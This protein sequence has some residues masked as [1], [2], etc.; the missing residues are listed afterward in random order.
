LQNYVLALW[1][2]FLS[3]RDDTA[4]QLPEVG[5]EMGPDMATPFDPRMIIGALPMPALL[6]GLDDTVV[7]ANHPGLAM[8]VRDGALVIGSNFKDVV[9][10]TWRSS[11]ARAL[12]EAKRTGRSERVSAGLD[13]SEPDARRGNVWVLPMLADDRRLAGMLVAALDTRE[14]DRLWADELQTLNEQLQLANETL[15]T[16][17][18][19]V[20]AARRADDERNQFLAML[21]HELRNPLAGI[22]SASY[23]LRQRLETGGDRT[24]EQALRVVDRQVKH[25]ARLLDDLL[26]VSRMVLG[27][28]ALR[29]ESVDLVVIVRQA[30][31]AASFGIHS[32]AQALRVELPD[33]PVVVTGDAIRL[34]QIVTNL[35]GN[36]VKYTPAAGRIDLRLSTADETAVLK[37]SDSGIGIEPE[38][39]DKIFELFTQGDVT[40]A[41]AAGGLGI[42]LTIARALVELH[43]GTITARSAGRDRGATFEVRL[44]R[45]QAPASAPPVAEP[46]PARAARRILVVDDNR[47]VR[48]LLRVVLELHGHRVQEAIDGVQAVKLA[49]EWV[50]DI[51]LIDIGLPEIDGYEVARRI[52]R[53]LGA[54]VRLFALTGYGDAEAHRLAV[55]AGF[56]Q[57]LVKPVDPNVL[58]RLIGAA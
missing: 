45:R 16:Q 5:P 39:L 14:S 1:L 42:G 38:L 24:V 33:E 29:L 48:E 31:E 32:R 22:A 11:L 41:R 58:A 7:A 18:Q 28:I 26:D 34:E 15:Q 8:F 36:A 35:L 17:L 53:R 27:K 52:R 13:E 30:I 55:E 54:S 40:R 4:T 21:A 57:H 2:D 50:P 3:T 43:G 9:T 10:D 20:H 37:V 44:P 12:A 19:E 6:L 46:E 23:V 49:V 47:D 51:A 56:D 25:Q